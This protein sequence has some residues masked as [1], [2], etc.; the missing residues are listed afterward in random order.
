MTRQKRIVI[1]GGSGFIGRALAKEFHTQ[2]CDV[3]I[4]TRAPRQ[5]SDAIQEVFWDGIH[6]G[7]WI[8]VLD[9]AEALINLTGKNINCPHTPANLRDLTASR[10]NSVN[11]L[12]EAG[13]HVKIPPQVW[14]Q[15]SAVG[16]YGDTRDRSCDESAPNGT[17][18]L[19]DICYQ[20]ENAFSAVKLPQTRKVT[21]R[22]GF[23]LGREGGALPVLASL[24]RV[25][26]GGA[27]GNGRQ[28]ISWIHL[29]DLVRMFVMAV[30]SE[31]LSGPFNAVAPGAVTNGEFMRKL[32]R[33]YHRPWSP[34]VPA[35]AVKLGAKLMGGEPSLALVSQRCVPTK[36]KAA[37]FRFQ[38]PELASALHDLC[39]G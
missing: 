9:G 35:F 29:A 31:K 30:E 38:F 18:T 15:A 8:S 21:L 19:A 13:G 27:A 26:L 34:P 7:E 20:W 10:V 1:A 33:T 24:T 22:I 16:F 25:F 3:V 5:R 4:L 17:G 14:V 11:T 36:F 2:G 37:G 39:H 6:I 32:R 12:A 28:Y 23:V